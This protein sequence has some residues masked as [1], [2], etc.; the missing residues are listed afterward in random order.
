ML[1]R[2]LTCAAV[3]GA[4]VLTT[5]TLVAQQA[6][7]AFWPGATYD[8][9]VPTLRQVLGHDPG[10][11]VTPPDQVG[12]YLR[13][14]AQ[15]DPARTRLVEYA[16]SWE[17]RPLWLMVIGSADRLARL[18]QVKSDLARLADPRGLS[19]AEADRLV[20][21]APVVVWLV[22]GVHGNEISSSDAALFEAY[23]L[24]AARG[25]ADV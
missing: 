8:P 24:L 18:D 23:H 20:R 3:A 14:L 6:P 21:E 10:T 9:A 2:L 19:A 4:L 16:R 25:D 5:P 11:E 17:G 1:A 15:A 22:H 13:A 12:E 7:E